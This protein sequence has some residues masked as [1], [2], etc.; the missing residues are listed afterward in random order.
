MDPTALLTFVVATVVV[1]V[2]P[3]PTVT[4]I[5]ANSLRH[6][7]RAGLMNIAGTQVGVLLLFGVLA[8]GFEAVAVQLA[9][10]FDWIRLVGAAYLVWLGVR[11][12]RSDGNLAAGEAA[13]A[14]SGTGFFLQGFLVILTNPKILFFLGAFLPQFIDPT[15]DAAAQVMGF[16]VLFVLLA[17]LL[18]GLYAFAAGRA[19]RLLTR[20]R[21]RTA[22]VL[23]GGA[24]VGG[25]IWMALQGRAA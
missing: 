2:V 21:V 20:R 3:G 25:G 7:T 15:G 9:W 19:G 6:G 13:P 23:G 17:T 1:L 18:D 12:L 16:G 10:A 4:V 5:V 24:L 8:L 14:R 22:E 11:M